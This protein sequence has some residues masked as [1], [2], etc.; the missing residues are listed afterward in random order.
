MKIGLL[1]IGSFV[2][3]RSHASKVVAWT[4]KGVLITAT[5]NPR[6]PWFLVNRNEANFD[7]LIKLLY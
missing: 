2:D 1:V 6:G 7:E 4:K 5:I 3:A